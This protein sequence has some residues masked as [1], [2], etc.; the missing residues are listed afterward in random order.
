M[1]GNNLSGHDRL[2]IDLFTGA[3]RLFVNVEHLG[4]LQNSGSESELWIISVTDPNDL[5]DIVQV[6]KSLA[7]WIMVFLLRPDRDFQ[8]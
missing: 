1:E 2:K 4:L 6:L 8:I 7:D 3:L 5:T